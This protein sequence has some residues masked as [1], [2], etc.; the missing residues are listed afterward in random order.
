M[1]ESFMFYRFIRPIA[2][3]VVWVLNGHLHVHHK[4]RL[5]KGNY[6]LVAPHRT[7]WEPILFALAASPDEFM[8]MAKVELFKNPILRFIMVH[9]HAFPVDRNHPGPSALR[10]PVKGLKQGKLSLIIFPSGTRHSAELKSGAFVIAKLA[11]KPLVPVVYQGPL[12]FGGLLRRQPME[13]C[14]GEAYDLNGEKVNKTT[15]P[16]LYDDLEKR[17]DKIDKEQNPSFKYIPH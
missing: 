7:W 1:E 4:E 10:T 13:I 5:P 8:F 14:F 3:F 9:A 2:R 15:I 6:V 16:D 11:K 12:T 17:W